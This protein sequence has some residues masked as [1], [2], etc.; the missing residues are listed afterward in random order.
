MFNLQKFLK[1]NG[2][3]LLIFTLFAALLIGW[4][5]VVSVLLGLTGEQFKLLPALFS[6][7]LIS[8]AVMLAW[9]TTARFVAALYD[10]SSP[11]AD[12]FMGYRLLGRSGF[13]PYLIIR[14]GK[15]VLGED[16][17]KKIGGPGGLVIY[18]DT[19]VVTEQYGRLKRVIRG[20]KFPSLEPFEKVWD[21]IDMRP[22]RWVFDVSAITYDGIPINYDADV[23]FQVRDTEQDIFKAATSK[24]VRDAWRT[25]PD[26]L[27]IWTKRV[28]IGETE[29][30][31]RAIL[32]HHTLN[33]LIDPDCRAA[34]RDELRDKLSKWAEGIG[35]E[36]VHVALGDIRLRGQVV[37]Q[38]IETWRAEREHQASKVIVEGKVERAKML[39]RARAQVRRQML[40]KTIDV[41]NQAAAAGER[42]SSR[43]VVLSF[44]EMLKRTS[45]EQSLYLPTDMVKTIDM[46]Q[47]RATETSSDS[48]SP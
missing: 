13:S 28:I 31:L 42:V 32:A 25:E 18:N 3:L 14:E 38:W 12:A 7:V 16:I 47:K 46:L 27:M 22:Q 26:R 29:G 43:L 2:K 37:Q 30:V 9:H 20:P 4:Y 33:Q 5:L 39:E 21:V 19:A 36:I 15:I 11:Q 8:L 35:V 48:P 45:F 17:V 6:I 23:R 34:V 40:E 10:V 1:R 24:W 44:I 41:F